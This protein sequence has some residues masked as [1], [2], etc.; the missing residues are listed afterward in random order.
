MKTLA[1]TL[2]AAA[3]VMPSLAFAAHP[4]AMSDTRAVLATVPVLVA[5]DLIAVD[6]DTIEM[7]EHPEVD[8]LIER[9]ERQSDDGTLNSHDMLRVRMLRRRL[10]S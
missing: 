10:A 8:R 7:A 9:L 5:P 4:M 6:P 2:L 1:P 3:L